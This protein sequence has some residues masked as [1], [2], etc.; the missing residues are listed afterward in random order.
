MAKNNRAL[1]AKISCMREPEA[2]PNLP[3]QEKDVLEF[4]DKHN[5]QD[6]Y[7]HRNDHSEKKFRFLDGPITA[8]N[9]MGVH[10]AHGRTIKDFFQRYKNMQGYKQR[11]QNGFDCQGLWVEVEEEKDLGFNSKRDIE[12]FGVDKFC[13]SCKARVDRFSVVQSAQSQ[14]LGM[15][16]DW[17][18]SYYTMSE[19]NN[20]HIWHFLKKINEKGWLYQ[21]VDAMPWCARCGTAISQHELSDGGYKDITHESVY[22]RFQL[23]QSKQLDS[24]LEDVAAVTS[25]ERVHMLAWTTTPWTLLA[26][27]ALAVNPDEQYVLLSE[28]ELLMDEGNTTYGGLVI[29]GKSTLKR[30]PEMKD[31]EILHEF[32]GKE[33]VGLIYKPLFDFTINN[34]SDN[35]P[36]VAADF[37]GLGDGTGIVHIAPSAGKE[38]FELSKS[39]AM[40]EKSQQSAIDEFGVYIDGYGEFTGKSVF[41]VRDRIFELLKE[42]GLFYKTESINHS[43]PHCWRCKH[44]LVFRTTKEWFIKA[45]EIRPH[46]KKASEKVNWMPAFAGK[47]M[48][49]WLDNMGDWPISRKR[50]WGLALPIYQNEAQSKF[51][52]IGSKAELRELAVDPNKVDQL[53]DLH[54]PWVD[55]IELDGGKILIHGKQQSGAWKRVKDVGDCWLDAGIVP[56]STVEYLTNREQWAQWYPFD[57]V[58]EY[59][60][61]IKLWFYATLFMSVALTIDEP[62]GPKAPWKNVLATG[63]LVDE[64]GKAMHKSAGNSIEFD[65]AAD[66]AGADTIRWLYLRERSANF[67][68][69]GNLRFG[70]NILGDVRR[71]FLMIFWN[72]Q[73][74]VVQNMLLDG[75]M[76]AKSMRSDLAKDSN[77][78]DRWI[79]S[80]FSELLTTVNISLDN[81]D[82]TTA[83][84]TIDEFVVNDF[85]Q[86]YIRRSR[87]RV[88]PT[89]TNLPEDKDAFYRTSYYILNQLTKL[90]APFV[91]FIA[92]SIYQNIRLES[93][94]LSVH[95]DSWP[96]EDTD[97]FDEK[98][99]RQMKLVREIVEIVHG[100]RKEQGIR[101]RQPLN[102]LTV[103][104]S[105][106]D[107]SINDLALIL[108]DEINVKEVTFAAGSTD[109]MEIFLD[110]VITSELKQEGQIRDINRAVQQLRREA[111]CELTHLV[112]LT[113]SDASPEILE[114]INQNQEMLKNRLLINSIE[115]ADQAG[116]EP[117][118][119]S[120]KLE[121]N[122]D[123]TN[124]TIAIKTV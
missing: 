80:R 44:E 36:V 15:F 119:F 35:F 101:L 122:L 49:D 115:F 96:T 23:E 108:A 107:K 13:T 70:Y 1:Y 83:A 3:A 117:T 10:H 116:S 100:I 43:Y 76:P 120:V 52:V 7:L 33:L 79:R 110:T 63:F 123:E 68:G 48:Q 113:V 88:G 56:F 46:M 103:K 87:D 105:D 65:K 12:N 55:E 57:F 37:V 111:G 98:V 95:L 71:R 53:P 61:Q 54:R 2:H 124:F 6:L 85:S 42:R 74:F 67:H 84:S 25:K 69:T 62:D 31:A 5:I 38:D 45:D 75:W 93:D 50:Y 21:G 51:Y 14:R 47:R 91:P 66:E 29:V 17:D 82:S 118:K 32:T 24:L 34:N 114:L 106:F 39:L 92:E 20:L 8:N 27:A 16:M 89:S 73:R 4:W 19:N 104:L 41:N 26:N 9:P 78:L 60:A 22:V 99:I 109:K 30:Q 18:N 77:V 90:L 72:T 102:G 40:S 28:T 64:K 112:H 121:S 59:I 58:T 81:F 86:W 11:F 97:C 94:P